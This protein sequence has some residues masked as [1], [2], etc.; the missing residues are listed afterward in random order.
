[1]GGVN[2]NPAS[3]AGPDDAVDPA[4]VGGK[5][6]YKHLTATSKKPVPAKWGRLGLGTGAG[7]VAES[8]IQQ[9]LD[10][11]RDGN[12]NSN[13]YMANL[14]KLGSRM[15]G[16]ATTG[17][18][19]GKNPMSALLGAIGGAAVDTGDNLFQISKILPELIKTYAEIQ[20]SNDAMLA[21]ERQGMARQ[22]QK[23]IERSQKERNQ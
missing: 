18:V 16:G 23:E 3:E 19:Y 20:K 1:M 10:A 6:I 2:Y 5:Q 13:P 15:T 21:K 7:V 4:I 22:I 9:L 17:A 14:E 12:P 8:T 11:T